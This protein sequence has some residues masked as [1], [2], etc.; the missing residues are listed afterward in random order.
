[1][2][3]YSEKVKLAVCKLLDHVASSKHNTLDMD[4]DED[5]PMVHVWMPPDS[6]KAK[7]HYV[8][9]NGTFS[10]SSRGESWSFLE[11]CEHVLAKIETDEV[12]E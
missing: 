2:N 4:T 3:D 6:F 7:R 8:V 10:L 11:C 12:S 1:M 5:F 9:K